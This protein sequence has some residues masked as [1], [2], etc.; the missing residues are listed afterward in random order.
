M[1]AFE[2]GALREMK[3]TKTKREKTKKNDKG[4]IYLSFSVLGCTTCFNFFTI[5]LACTKRIPISYNVFNFTICD[6]KKCFSFHL[7]EF[8]EWDRKEDV[9]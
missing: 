2:L 9:L 1:L 7:S 5:Q 8:F 6:S 3:E 4:T